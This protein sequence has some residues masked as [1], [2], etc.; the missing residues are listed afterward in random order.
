MDAT[1]LYT[2]P[3]TD[4]PDLIVE[5]YG[6]FMVVRRASTGAEVWRSTKGKNPHLKLKKIAPEL[7]EYERALKVRPHTGPE[8]KPKEGELC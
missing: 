6:D 8:R 2:Y 4:A 3:L 5:D 1:P 7:R